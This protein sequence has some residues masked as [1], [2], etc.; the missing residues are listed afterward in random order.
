M[1]EDRVQ[2][3]LER[4]AH[5][6]AQRDADTT[7]AARYDPMRSVN[8]FRSQQRDWAVARLLHRN[9]VHS[10]AGLD[11]LE[12]GCGSG[13][14]LGRLVGLGADERRLAGIDLSEA[15]ID[16][17]RRRLPGADLRVGSAHALPFPDASVDIVAQFTLF[18]SVV[19]AAVREAI[20]REMQRVLRPAGRVL[21]YEAHRATPT[22]DFVPIP[23][24]ELR[25]LFQGWRIDRASTTL[26]WW[27]IERVAPRS[28]FAAQVMEL[29]PYLCSHTVAV[30]QRG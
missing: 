11:I 6:Y 4:A 7:S 16:E 10:L 5:A 17:A 12:V 19:D 8:L 2:R 23:D 30:L 24:A 22:P 20:A 3:E 14:I 9:D 26:R 21:W 13:G 27:L 28:R 1:L 15:R 29:I 18:S 25:A